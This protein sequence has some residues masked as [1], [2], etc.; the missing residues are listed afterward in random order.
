MAIQCSF[1]SLAVFIPFVIYVANDWCT[2][3]L[4]PTKQVA[5]ARI[6]GRMVLRHLEGHR[7]TILFLNKQTQ[8]FITRLFIY[9][10]DLLKFHPIAFKNKEDDSHLSMNLIIPFK[11]LH[12]PHLQFS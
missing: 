11:D 10:L 2:Y 12:T 9:F 7:Y 4:V 3:S 8:E 5:L 6:D 1:L